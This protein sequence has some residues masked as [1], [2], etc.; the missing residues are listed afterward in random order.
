MLELAQHT[1]DATTL[2]IVVQD[3]D[4][5]AHTLQHHLR[6]ESLEHRAVVCRAVEGHKRN[7]FFHL[8]SLPPT[9]KT[10][11]GC[12]QIRKLP[13]A[14]EPRDE[15]E[16]GEVDQADASEAREGGQQVPGKPA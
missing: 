10:G 15:Q 11:D 5:V 6:G 2:R 3:C 12:E 16:N 4:V 9:R 1:G 8:Y 7:V 14:E 13:H